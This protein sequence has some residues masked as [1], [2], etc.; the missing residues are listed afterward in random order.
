MGSGLVRGDR[1]ATPSWSGP[2]ALTTAPAA[3]GSVLCLH[4]D[5]RRCH[6]PQVD[7]LTAADAAGDYFG[8]SVA[9]DGATPS[10]SGP[11]WRRSPAPA[12]AQPTSSYDRRDPKDEFVAPCQDGRPTPWRDYF[13]IS[14]AID[15]DTVVVVPPRKDDDADSGSGSA[16]VFR[17]TTAV[18]TYGLVAKLT[19]SD[20]AAG[21]EFWHL[22]GDLRRHHRD[23]DRTTTTVA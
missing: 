16:Y 20:A 23:W 6:V 19:A 22:R 5:R 13:G 11:T 10:W 21:D 4:H 14:V 18:A 12:R 1:L 15:G 8:S 3:P 2:G 7:K 17:T 9:I